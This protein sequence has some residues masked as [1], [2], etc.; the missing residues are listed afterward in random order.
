MGKSNSKRAGSLKEGEV[1]EFSKVSN[2]SQ[3]EICNLYEY[4]KYFSAS[5][6]DDGVIDY[7]EF[8]QALNIESSLITKRIFQIFDTNSDTVINFREFLIGIAAFFNA[9]FEDQTKLTFQILTQ[10]NMEEDDSLAGLIDSPAK[11]EED[12]EQFD[13][14]SPANNSPKCT[15]ENMVL[16]LRES[17]DAAYELGGVYVPPSLIEQLVSEAFLHITDSPTSTQITFEEYRR[18]LIHNRQILKWL[19]IDINQ[20]IQG[21]KLL[22]Q[23]RKKSSCL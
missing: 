20:I 17:L 13:W 22:T 3:C 8:C 7:T 16:I 10:V 18:M 12:K 5:N 14:Q 2:F 19:T 9:S 6:I 4:Y 21:V 1:R 15:K 11:V 23:P